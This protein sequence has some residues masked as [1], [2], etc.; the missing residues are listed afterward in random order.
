M[1][2]WHFC[3][4]SNLQLGPSQ[5]DF[6]KQ[7]E[8]IEGAIDRLDRALPPLSY[9]EDGDAIATETMPIHIRMILPRAMLQSAKINL[10]GILA[11][12]Q[13][14][15]YQRALNAAEDIMAILHVIKHYDFNSL[16]VALAVCSFQLIGV[17]RQKAHGHH[18]LKDML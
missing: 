13:E 11:D 3:L 8:T 18:T 6:V 2:A 15:A 14:G 1:R 12:H 4:T 16:E 7:Y 10:Y 17:V 5:A 9:S